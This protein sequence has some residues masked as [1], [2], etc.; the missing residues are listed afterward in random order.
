MSFAARIGQAVKGAA[1]MDFTGAFV[2]A[3]KAYVQ[4]KKTVYYP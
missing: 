1:L 4:P 2:L 3:M